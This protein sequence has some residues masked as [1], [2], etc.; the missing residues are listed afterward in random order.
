[1]TRKAAKTGPGAMVLVA[2][3]QGFPENQRIITD[4]LAYPIRSLSQNQEDLDALRSRLQ[5][6][7]DAQRDSPYAQRVRSSNL[8]RDIK[9][10]KLDLQWG[11]AFVFFDLPEKLITDPEDRSTH[12]GPK[13]LAHTLGRV[14]RELLIFSPY[15]V[16]G[17]DGVSRL[18]EL[19]RRGVQVRVLTNS[20]ASTDVGLVHA[21]Y[22]KYR[23]PLLREGV[24]IYELK[25]DTD[26]RAKGRFTRLTG[27]SGS[28]LHAKTSVF[29]REM[30]FVGSANLDPRSGKLNTELGI[31][32]ESKPLANGL[33]NWFD[34]NWQRIAYQVSL[35]QS[36][37]ADDRPC[38]GQLQWT[39]W[40]GDREV[41]YLSEPQTGFLTRFFLGLVSLLPIE[42]Q[43]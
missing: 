38:S 7:A 18:T 1:M 13:A 29:D 27:S 8:L 31:F 9:D 32:F 24:E 12:M 36:Q 40:E 25:P 42:G 19:E 35:D 14:K 5:E 26:I 11:H 17:D 21:G 16:P 23:E 22:A 3:E 10:E 15:F 4:E 6:H 33:A 28:A 37:C 43:L 2:I 20:L 39:A 34:D 30:L 41:V